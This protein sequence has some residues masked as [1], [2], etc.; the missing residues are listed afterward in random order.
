MST[1]PPPIAASV[2][3][4]AQPGQAGLSEAQRLINTFIA[5]RKTF[6]D[7]QRNASWWL[8]WLL[9]SIFAIAF[10]VTIDKKVGFDEIAQRI[11]A[12]NKQV[13]SQ[14]PEQQARTASLVATSTKFSGYA[15]PIFILLYALVT[16]A[17]LMATFNFGMDAQVPFGRSLAIVMYGWLP[18]LVSSILAMVS[19]AFGDP[20][21]FRL[22]NPVGTN[23][24][25]F[26]DPNNTSKFVLG[27]LSSFDVISLWIVVLLGIGFAVNAKKKLQPGTAIGVVAAWYFLFKLAVAGLAGLRG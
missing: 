5:P 6:E 19:L 9:I 20:E 11:L 21:G 27:L 1:P 3:P 24:A 7:L 12:S 10:F 14:T 22:E 15:S 17:V 18:N 25:Y 13:Q 23:P 16:A 8:P 4:N 2:P 26:M